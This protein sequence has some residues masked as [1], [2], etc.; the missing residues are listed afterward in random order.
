M[1]PGKNGSSAYRGSVD[2]HV[3]GRH[4]NAYL[5]ALPLEVLG[6]LDVFN[7]HNGSV[8]WSD[9][10]SQLG[11]GTAG[12]ISEELKHQTQQHQSCNEVCGDGPVGSLELGE[13]DVGKGQDEQANKNGFGSFAVKHIDGFKRFAGL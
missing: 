8:G 7:D 11:D 9:Y 12:R 5:L 4:K 3:Q 10:V 6:L 1:V 2:V 13:Q